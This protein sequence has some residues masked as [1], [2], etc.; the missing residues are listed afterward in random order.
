MIQTFAPQTPCEKANIPV[1]QP[2]SGVSALTHW[3]V[4]IH[5]VPPTAPFLRGADL[6]IASDCVPAAY[7]R[8][9][10]DLL[11]GK[12]VLM[13][14]PKFDDAEAYVRKLAAI[15]TEA[16]LKSITVAVMEVPCCQ[17]M[18]AIVKKALSLAEKEIPMEVVTISTQGE[19]LG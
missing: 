1:S 17:G 8:F 5:L 12:T 10:D 4:Q 13:G 11:R 15:F 2:A 19:R 16:G 14:C 9:H 3:P 6:L 18:P 7:H